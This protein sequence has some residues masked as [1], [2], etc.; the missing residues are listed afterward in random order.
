VSSPEFNEKLQQARQFAQFRNFGN[1]LRLYSQ[2]AKE[3][4]EGG[5]WEEYG[6][7]AAQAGEFDL[8][9]Q[10]WEKLRTL[11][12]NT[13]KLLSKLASEYGNIWLFA[14]AREFSFKAAELDPGNLEVQVNLAS[15]LSRTNSVDEAREAVERCLKLDP[16]SEAA[17]YLSAHL[18]RRED[19]LVEAEQQFR[20]MLA[21]GLQD[22]QVRYFCHLE[23]ARI[24]DRTERF[25]E[26][27]A[28]LAEAK[29][30]AAQS[31]NIAE[32]EKTFDERRERVVRKANALPKNILAVWEK[33]FP[34]EA[35]T[36]VPPIVFLGGHARSG[37]TLLERILDAHPSV[38]ACDEALAFQTIAPLVDVTAPEIPVDGL[39]FLRRRYVRNLTKVLESSADGKTLVDKNPPATAYLPA[40]LRAFPELRVLIALRDPRDVLVSCYFQTLMQVS[41]FSFERL[42]QHYGCI[43]DVWLAV[44]EWEGLTWM[45]TRYEDIVADLCA[46]GTR[47]TKFLG[48]EWHENQAQFYEKNR[49]KPVLSSNYHDVTKPVYKRSVGRWQ[50][51]EEYLAPALPA[52]EPYCKMFGYA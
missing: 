8:A 11:E 2:L 23:L 31:I 40:F 32:A 25:D 16:R 34:P 43:M 29:R 42:A 9:E 17:R 49:Q 47:I 26:A 50:A 21:C 22:W 7:V 4:S 48:S 38:A 10:I 46:E 35:R 41:H 3:C 19:K 14:K 28:E 45:E 5:F 39:N 24:F 6:S 52:L 51:Y 13:A 30:L 44:R 15:F 36:A 37:T 18:C 12:P 20:D 1:A 27:M 33:A